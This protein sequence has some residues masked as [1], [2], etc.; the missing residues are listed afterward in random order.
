MF[1]YIIS[2]CLLKILKMH[3]IKY[4]MLDVH[5]GKFCCLLRAKCFQSHLHFGEKGERCSL[6]FDMF[7]NLKEYQ[8][9]QVYI[10]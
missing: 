9:F 6:H 8:M 4:S 3:V 10:F 7:S 1:K 2:I 5:V